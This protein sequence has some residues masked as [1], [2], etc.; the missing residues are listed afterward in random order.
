M[1]ETP[2]QESWGETLPRVD[3]AGTRSAESKPA[4]SEVGQEG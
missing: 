4:P 1:V 2:V 3:L